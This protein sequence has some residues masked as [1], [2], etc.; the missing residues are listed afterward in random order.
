LVSDTTVMDTVQL[1]VRVPDLVDFSQINTHIWNLTGAIAGKHADNHWCTEKIL[2]SLVAAVIDFYSWSGS[3]ENEG[4]FIVLAINDMTLR[5]GGVF[6]IDG[7]WNLNEKHSFHR[8]G[9]S[10]DINRDP[11]GL[12]LDNGTL[13]RTGRKLNHIMQKRGAR[14]YPEVRIHFGF[15]NGF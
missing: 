11:G 8:V 10:V 6:D 5:W 1:T 15:D 4:R 13:T 3:E 7:T 12:R 2:D 14:K 9:L